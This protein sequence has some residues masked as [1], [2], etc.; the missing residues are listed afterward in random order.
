MVNE[1]ATA[2]KFASTGSVIGNTDQ[3]VVTIYSELRKGIERDLFRDNDWAELRVDADLQLYEGLQDYRVP[4]DFD[5]FINGTMWDTVDRRPI[6]GPVGPTDWQ[7]YTTSVQNP[8]Y[9]HTFRIARRPLY[10]YTIGSWILA[11]YY[12]CLEFYEIPGTPLPPSGVYT[13]YRMVTYSYMSNYYVQRAS[14]TTAMPW[15][16]SDNDTLLM[17]SECAIQAGTVRMLRSMG[18][19]F[20]DEMDELNALLKERSLKDGG[21]TSINAGGPDYGQ[22]LAN[23][24][25]QYNTLRGSARGF[26]FYRPRFWRY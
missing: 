14:D 22:P 15:F 10:G 21:A 24:G 7:A 26:G 17:D 5:S 3:N 23:C 16:T 1:I 6:W 2:I 20:A 12:K 4:L 8:G 18:L 11:G 19:N 13:A 25:F 9:P